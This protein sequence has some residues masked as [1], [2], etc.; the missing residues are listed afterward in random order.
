MRGQLRFSG[1]G[2]SPIE[3]IGKSNA[4]KTSSSSGV[5]TPH[6]DTATGDLLIVCM[7]TDQA[8]STPDISGWTTIRSS[9]GTEIKLKTQYFYHDGSASYTVTCSGGGTPLVARMF[10]FRNTAASSPIAG[11]LYATYSV[12]TSFPKLFTHDSTTEDGS[13]VMCVAGHNI[14]LS[15]NAIGSNSNSTLTDYTE[16]DDSTTTI[17]YDGGFGVFGGWK[18]TAGVVG[19]TTVEF[20]DAVIGV[21]HRFHIKP[22]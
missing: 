15:S 6:A 11:L 4:V 19:D 16:M 18:D 7:M 3:Y 17:G 21:S 12:G 22:L 10:T 8:D 9:T 5:L 13:Y 20:N 1:G 14:T 2:A